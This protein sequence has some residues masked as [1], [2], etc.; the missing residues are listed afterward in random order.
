MDIARRRLHNERLIAAPFKKPEDV[1]QWL[2][3]VQAQDYPGAKWGI[4]QRVKDCVDADVERAY[5]S[6]TILRTHVM[7]PTWHF[8]MPADI[9]WLLELTAPR[10]KAAMATYDRKLELDEA[11]YGR[12]N[13]AI[14]LALRGG[15]HLTRTEVSQVLAGAGIAATGQRLGHI[16][17]RA[18]LDAVICS[19]AMRGKQHTHAL[20]EERAPE[21]KT[22]KRDEA[23]AEL[24]RRYFTS[25]GPALVQDFAWWSGLTVAEA[26][27]GVEMTKVHLLHEVV[28]DKTYWFAPSG[29]VTRVKDPTIHL[30]PNY[31]EF[32]IAYRDHSASLDESLPSG[33]A[34]MYDMLSRHII[35]LNGKVIGGWRNTFKKNGVTIETKL[36]TPLTEGQREALHAAAEH[37]ERFL[38]MSVTVG[39]DQ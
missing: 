25:H 33:S 39:F 12:S 37:Y 38:G 24:A 32:L 15:T 18:E 31:D 16:V 4:G 3:A 7:R 1:V 9:R 5:V 29:P 27:A 23:L 35:V 11:L 8:V 30:L 21:A 28:G 36:I 6:G 20:L 10:V 19:G 2:C 14:A 17:M 13:A 26:K 22:L 34:A